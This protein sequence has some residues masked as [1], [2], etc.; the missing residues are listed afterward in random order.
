MK[1]MTGRFHLIRKI[2]LDR[3]T[4][5]QENRYI[6]E[7]RKNPNYEGFAIGDL[8]YLDVKHASYL[9]IPSQKLDKKR[10]NG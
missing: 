7:L 8:V 9:K 6:K 10:L 5:D 3:K 4:M 2:V 1:L